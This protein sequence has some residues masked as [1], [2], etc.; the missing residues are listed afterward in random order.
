MAWLFLQKCVTLVPVAKPTEREIMNTTEIQILST[1]P[2][3]V[4]ARD[5]NSAAANCADDYAN[6]IWNAMYARA[7]RCEYPNDTWTVGEPREARLISAVHAHI[8]RWQ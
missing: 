3:D 8:A 4:L 5:F 7:Y 1:K 2:L 6:D